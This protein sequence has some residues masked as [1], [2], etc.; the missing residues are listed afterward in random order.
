METAEMVEIVETKDAKT[1]STGQVTVDN[2]RV[3]RLKEQYV[4][5]PQAIDN[6]RTVIMADVYE[7]TAGYQQIIRRAKFFAS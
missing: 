6:E 2:A 1:S 4:S 3:D 5:T 7:G